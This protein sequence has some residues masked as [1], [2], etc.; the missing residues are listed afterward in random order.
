MGSLWVPF[1]I[2]WGPFGLL[3]G[4]FWS[5]SS[6]PPYKFTSLKHGPPPVI[7][8]YDDPVEELQEGM[9]VKIVGLVGN[10]V[11][12]GCAG[13]LLGFDSDSGR[14]KVELDFLGPKK[15]KAANIV[16]DEDPFS[17]DEEEEKSEYEEVSGGRA[18]GTKTKTM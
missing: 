2:L 16:I 15:I 3:L 14:W 6:T 1:G 18:R 4:C 5:H 11:L 13:V 7:S 12:N 17:Q 10:P 9:C 8:A